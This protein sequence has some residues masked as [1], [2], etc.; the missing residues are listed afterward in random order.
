LVPVLQGVFGVRARCRVDAP[1]GSG[2]GV[3]P[4]WRSP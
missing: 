1:V 2:M 3:H 4:L